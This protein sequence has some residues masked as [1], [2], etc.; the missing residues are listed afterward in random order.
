M[1]LN[2]FYRPKSFDQIIGNK[3]TVASLKSIYGRETDYPH[4]V[5]LQGPRGCGKT[6]IAKI[7]ATFLLGT[8]IG[9][10]MG[11]FQPIDGGDVNAERVR[12]FK[13]Q[14]RFKPSVCKNRVWI[15]DECF[16]AGTNIKTPNGDKRI[17]DVKPGDSVFSL[18]G[19]DRVFSVFKSDISLERLMV[20]RFSNGQKVYTTKDHLIF[21]INGWVEAKNL[22][23][24]DLI[25]PYF[26]YNMAN[27]LRD[28]K[29]V[30]KNE[31][32]FD[33]WRG[34]KEKGK[35]ILLQGMQLG[36]LST[37]SG[38][39]MGDDATR[40]S[41]EKKKK[42]K[43]SLEKYVFEG[44]NKPWKKAFF[45]AE[46]KEPNDEPGKYREN[47]TNK[48][49]KGDIEH[50][51]RRERRQRKVYSASDIIGICFKLA[52]GSSNFIKRQICWVSDL[53]QSGCGKFG[54]KTCDRDRRRRAFIERSYLFR[55]EK[56]GKIEAIRMESS[57]VYKRG[58]NDNS[59]SGI[60]GDKERNRKAVVCYDLQIEKHPSYFANEVP[61]HNCHMIGQ[62]GASEKNIPQNNM[63]TLLEECPSHVYFILCTTDPGRLL[64][65]IQSRCHI[66]EVQQ[67]KE[68]EILTLLGDV[69]AKEQVV[70][71]GDILKGIADAA[72]GCPRDA[73]KILDQIIDMSPQDMIEGIRSFLYAENNVSD[74]CKALLNKQSWRRVSTI[75]KQMDLS[76]AEKIRRAVTAWMT[77]EMM[78]NGSLR[79]A[80]IYECFK[81][82]FYVNGKHDL[83][84]ACFQVCFE[85]S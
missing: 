75:L 28:N 46:V 58:S 14:V 64:G 81:S 16:P 3:G 55:S 32:M 71:S 59:F 65:T 76:E 22:T 48:K 2:L 79:A 17:E 70:V 52:D 85:P 74:L 69:A 27:T 20:L 44:Q 8:E 49:N 7:I 10:A 40:S 4:A 67:L 33:L 80:F 45:A 60:I 1:P 26:P 47:E 31:K 39:Q 56:R 83:V 78:K 19:E 68:N 73:L 38:I 36:E 25:F 29:G 11:D 77:S 30:F 15:I 37:A 63:L 84:N 66:F 41:A 24:K 62:G 53:L 9:Q 42:Y 50:L 12:D 82:S 43:R 54:I 57:E 5:L 72:D 35:Q 18:A 61:V 6:T 51:E 21:T 23:K 34:Y 13:S